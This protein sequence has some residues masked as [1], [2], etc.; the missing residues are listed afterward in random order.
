NAC[1]SDCTLARCGDGVTDQGEDCDDGNQV[2]G[3]SCYDC[4]RRYYFIADR[5]SMQSLG[6]DSITRVDRRGHS[7]V[8]IGPDPA[9]NGMFD[10]ELSRDGKQL[11]VGQSDYSLMQHRLL[12]IDPASGDM[13][14]E[15]KLDSSVLGYSVSLGTMT[16]GLN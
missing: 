15:I 1:R 16:L 3:D 11:Y 5:P 12:I 9:L 8:L 6:D 4:S 14:D 7:V 10:L 2:W 13:I